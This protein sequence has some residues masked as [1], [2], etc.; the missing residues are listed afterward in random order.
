MNIDEIAEDVVN[1]FSE[2]VYLYEK[3]TGWNRD[4]LLQS[5]RED[6]RQAIKEMLHQ[7]DYDEGMFSVV[8]HPY[9]VAKSLYL[10]LTEDSLSDEEKI[11]AVKLCYFCLLKNY[12]K[13]KDEIL[14]NYEFGDLISGCKLA[15]VLISMQAQ[16]LMLSVIMGQ[17]QY[18]DPQTHIKNQILLFG[19]VIKE[20]ENIV[21]TDRIWPMEAV[22]KDYY[23]DVYKELN[24]H[25]IFPIGRELAM[26]KERCIPII[27]NIVT[28]ISVNLKDSPDFDF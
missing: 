22:I 21:D 1:Q 5:T 2:E 7:M 8:E 3:Y 26:H 16:Y 17:A 18:I 15:L 6:K 13:N 27:K 4:T 14:V 9:T 10:M 23:E 25:F 28:S 24:G 11:S 20:A 12:L 19:G